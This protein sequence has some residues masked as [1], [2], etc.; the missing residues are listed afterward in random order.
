MDRLS[1]FGTA[2]FDLIRRGSDRTEWVPDYRIQTFHFPGGD[3]SESQG[4]GRGV[5]QLSGTARFESS[6]EFEAFAAL[7]A[8]RQ[9]LR[10]P[11]MATAFPGDR[12]GQEFDQLYKEFDS[13]LLVRV[14][15]IRLHLNGMVDCRATWERNP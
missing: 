11:F 12:Q 6:D 3:V 13:V 7:A 14:D 15:E 4:M 10:V 1:R 8:T 9:T 5:Y 2:A